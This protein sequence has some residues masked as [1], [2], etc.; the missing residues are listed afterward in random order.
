[1][2]HRLQRRKMIIPLPNKKTRKL[3]AFRSGELSL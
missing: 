1:M 3:L 2:R